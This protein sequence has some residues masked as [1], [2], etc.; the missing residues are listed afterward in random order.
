MIMWPWKDKPYRQFTVKAVRVTQ[1]AK[2][3]KLVPVVIT[4]KANDFEDAA[5]R[6]RITFT[7]GDFGY[8]WTEIVS[9]REDRLRY[10]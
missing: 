6:V 8:R 5:E 3:N 1:Y 10:A 4:V 2:S 7:D 9:V